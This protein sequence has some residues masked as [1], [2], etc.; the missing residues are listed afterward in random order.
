MQWEKQAPYGE[1][2]VGLD[3]RTPGLQS[4]PKADTQPLNH[5]GAPPFILPETAR[6]SYFL[7]RIPHLLEAS[8]K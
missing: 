3:P 1:P 7:L 4:E 5:P 2:D 8:F 6:L